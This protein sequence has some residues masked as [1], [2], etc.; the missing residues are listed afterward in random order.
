MKLYVIDIGWCIS[1][2]Q[3][4]T[5]IMS[6]CGGECYTYNESCVRLET[7]CG[8]SIS[9]KYLVHYTYEIALNQNFLHY[10]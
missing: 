8:N 6:V 7:N 10:T 3:V 2:H 9:N 5:I 1:G 4:S